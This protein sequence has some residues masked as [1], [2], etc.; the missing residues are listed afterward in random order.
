MEAIV[1]KLNIEKEDPNYYK[2]GPSPEIRDLD[3]YYYL[4]VSGGCSPSSSDFSLA[5]ERL[6]AVAYTIKFL[7]KAKKQA[8]LRKSQ[9]ARPNATR[10]F[11]FLNRA[12]L[13]YKSFRIEQL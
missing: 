2:T 8:L 11:A 6:Y 13:T 7:Y 9:E 3:P 4:T 1:K 5:M 10:R 12:Y